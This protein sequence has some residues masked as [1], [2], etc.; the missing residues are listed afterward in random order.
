MILALGQAVN[1]SRQIQTWHEYWIHT[2]SFTQLSH[3]HIFLPGAARVFFGLGSVLLAHS[4]GSTLLT[5]LGSELWR[6]AFYIELY[7]KV[8]N[9]WD[10]YK[11]T[12]G[13]LKL[14]KMIGKFMRRRKNYQSI[15]F[16]QPTMPSYFICRLTCRYDLIAGMYVWLINR[17][18]L[19][20]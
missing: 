20:K 11:I 10:L 3:T 15:F 5:Q 4:A 9:H 6:W 7:L 12:K 2:Q 8:S 18:I 16:W 19:L 13:I 14:C 1:S 17:S